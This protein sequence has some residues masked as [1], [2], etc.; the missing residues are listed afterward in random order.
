MKNQ[1]KNGY[2]EAE[3]K[4]QEIKCAMTFQEIPVNIEKNIKFSFFH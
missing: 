2:K 3:Y 1:K 4:L